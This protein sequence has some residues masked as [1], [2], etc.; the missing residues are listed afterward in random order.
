MWA[1]TRAEL[2]TQIGARRD[3]LLVGLEALR[4]TEEAAA[5]LRGTIAAAAPSLRAA[6]EQEAHLHVQIAAQELAAL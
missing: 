6:A 2:A 5:E 3:G 4:A 1:H